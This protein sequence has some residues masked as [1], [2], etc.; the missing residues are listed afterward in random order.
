[1]MM[2]NFWDIWREKIFCCVYVALGRKNSFF[3]FTT[4]P[5]IHTQIGT[6][7]HQSDTLQQPAFAGGEGMQGLI[8]GTIQ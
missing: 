7:Q 3:Y 4:I 6:L 1:M 2:N 8:T 5:T